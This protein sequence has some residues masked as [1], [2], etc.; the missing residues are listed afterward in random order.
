MKLTKAAVASDINETQRIN[1]C[2]APLWELFQELSS[3]RVVYAMAN[4]MGLTE[5]APHL[6]ILPVAYSECERVEAALDALNEI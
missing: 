6:P 4:L 3:L 1:G 5:A 2:F